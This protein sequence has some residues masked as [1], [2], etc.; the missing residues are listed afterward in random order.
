M[1]KR[2]KYFLKEWRGRNQKFLREIYAD[3]DLLKRRS[4]QELEED[5]Q[6]LGID[7]KSIPSLWEKIMAS[8]KKRR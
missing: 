4:P 8:K 2:E 6:E 3:P 7:P 1:N 5:L